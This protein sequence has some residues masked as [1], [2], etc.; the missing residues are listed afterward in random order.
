MTEPDIRVKGN[1]VTESYVAAV[2]DRSAMIARQARD[3]VSAARTELRE[4]GVSV[5]TYRRLTL[6]DALARL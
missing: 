5:E 1:R 4:N 2:L 3:E 6:D